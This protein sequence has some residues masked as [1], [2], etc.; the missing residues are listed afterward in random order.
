MCFLDSLFTLYLE[1]LGFKNLNVYWQLIYNKLNSSLPLPPRRLITFNEGKRYT[2]WEK[3]MFTVSSLQNA[4]SCPQLIILYT[5]IWYMK[6]WEQMLLEAIIQASQSLISL[7]H[8]TA[9]LTSYVITLDPLIVI[10]LG[11]HRT[12]K[13]S[14]GSS[15]W[16]EGSGVKL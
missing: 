12:L 2:G 6:L 15:L 1:H 10:I 7:L 14:E 8:N 13:S 16:S 5:Y 3:L 11:L 4:D 9:N